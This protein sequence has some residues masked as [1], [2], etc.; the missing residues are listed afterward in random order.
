MVPRLSASGSGQPVEPGIVR[1]DH[2]LGPAFQRGAQIGGQPGQPGARIDEQGGRGIRFHIDRMEAQ[3]IER[4]GRIGRIAVPVER[5]G[6]MAARLVR[7]D[8]PFP[9]AV[10]D[11]PEQGAKAALARHGQ[12]LPARQDQA[13]LVQ[14]GP[15]RRF[16]RGRK[17]G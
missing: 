6:R 11:R 1:R 7:H 3:R 14:K 10:E 12:A 5:A 9:G 15:Q 16:L 4:V 2:V 8:A 13:L 17:R